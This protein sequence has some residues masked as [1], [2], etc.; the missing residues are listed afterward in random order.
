MSLSSG[1]RLGPY[2]ILSPLGAGGMGEVYRARD[3]RLEREVALKILGRNLLADDGA[4]KRFRKEAQ[5]LAKLNHSHIAQ[6]HDFATEEGVDFLVMELVPGETL[7]ER[8]AR[9][10]LSEAEVLKIGREL[11]EG[12]AAAHAEGVVHCDLKP[13]NLRLSKDGTLKI[14]DF[15]LAR[16]KRPMVTGDPTASLTGTEIAVSGTLPYMAPEQLRAESLDARTDLW[17]AGA[18]LYELATRTRPFRETVSAK[19][20]DAILHTEP[21][22]PSARREGISPET[23]K[24]ILKCLEKEPGRRYQSA[25]DLKSDLERL[26]NPT[27]PAAATT[28]PRR[29]FERAPVVAAA[30][31]LVVAVT[32]VVFFVK[33]WRGRGR[34]ASPAGQIASLAVL[35]LENMTGDPGQEY[36]ADGMTEALITELAKIRSLKVISRT[37]VMRFKKTTS[38]LPEIARQLGVEGIIEGSVARGSGRVKIT[39]QLIQAATDQHIWAD[40]FERPEA[41]VLS[42]QSDVARAIAGQVRAVVTPDEQK[43]LKTN[44]KVNPEAYDLALRSRHLCDNAS[45]PEDVSRARELAERAVKID[46]E[47]AEA[48]AALANVL[49][50][51][52]NREPG[53]VLQPLICSA[54]DRALELD[55]KLANAHLARGW[56]STL[57]FDWERAGREFRTATEVAPSDGGAF[58]AYGYWLA[59]MGHC[60]EGLKAI[61]K[62]IEQ[63][64]FNLANRCNLTNILYAARRDDEAVTAARAILEIAPKWFWAHNNLSSLEF[65][66]GRRDEAL[67]QAVASWKIAWGD[68]QLPAGMKWDA[69][70][71]W[72]PEELKRRNEKPWLVSGFIAA[73]YAMYGQP[74]KAFPYI[75]RSSEV[76]DAWYIQLFWP[77]F[78]SLRRDPRFLALIK[79][80]N[81]PVHVYDRP[82]REVAAAKR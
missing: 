12:L 56:A 50:G 42:L 65:L 37:S 6:V 82:Y 68:F 19:L 17:G 67:A 20:T 11:A 54:A 72:I 45:G 16:L 64:P 53:Q 7:S 5:A 62:G 13:A 28:A 8:L 18:V 49:M 30:I 78:D 1:T 32:G 48:Q 3:T 58:G 31:V 81:L 26:A 39:A 27:V 57:A 51:F 71:R 38:A 23:S 63:E 33:P 70:A 35:P 22:P 21:D 75:E 36:F 47:S 29:F 44:R 59:M 9:G 74:E 69:Y 46:P 77:E 76:R 15:G 10:P 25:N 61:R 55:P 14:L 43:L 24:V 4:R 34:A 73:S 40:S 41:D 80:M 60:D 66:K 2:E 79:R 52:F